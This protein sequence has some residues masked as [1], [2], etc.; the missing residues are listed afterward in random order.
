MTELNKERS[1]TQSKDGAATLNRGRQGSNRLKLALIGLVFAGVA[2]F[3]HH[4]AAGGTQNPNVLFREDMVNTGV[5]KDASGKLSGMLI[6]NGRASK[7]QLKLSVSRLDN[8]AAYRL[9]AFIGNETNPRN[10]TEFTTD[11]KGSFAVTYVEKGPRGSSPGGEPLPDVLDPI[12]QI[13]QLDIVKAG[14]VVLTAVV[15][16]DIPIDTTP[17][18]VRATDPRNAATGVAINTKIAAT[19]S[20]AMDPATINTNTFTIKQGATPVAGRVSYVG[21]TATFAPA[22]ALASN[23]TYTATITSSAKDLAGNA[24]VSA[25]TWSFTTIASMDRTAPTVTATDPRN[26][27][28]GVAINKKITATFSEA[29]N[30]ATISTTTF[31]LKQGATPVAGA[32]TY[33][34]TTATFAPAS[35]LAANKTY[36]ATISSGAKDLAGNALASPFVWSFT[37]VAAMDTTAPTVTATSPEIGATGVGINTESRGPLQ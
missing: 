32:V 19:F 24:L 33:V 12:S 7:Q 30:P 14:R 11:R 29:M 26:A 6:A 31:T 21:T 3:L 9:V 22:S 36:T 25:F 4:D 18:T 34:G 15:G 13:R 27:A 16:R 20:E 28:T 35:A 5:D 10:V 23:T 37:T 17:P 1:H 8:T 2:M